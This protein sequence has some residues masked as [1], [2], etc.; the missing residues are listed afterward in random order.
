[1]SAEREAIYELGDIVR[2]TAGGP[3]MTINQLISSYSGDRSFSGNYK[4]QWFAGKKLD[5]GTFPEESLE[6]VRKRG[7]AK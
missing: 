6:L 1:M 3:E 5:S 4:A 7:E 2:L